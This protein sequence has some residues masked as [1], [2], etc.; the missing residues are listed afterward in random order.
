[1]NVKILIACIAWVAT[2][3]PSLA[4]EWPTGQAADLLRIAAIAPAE[5]LA[6][7]TEKITRL[8]NVLLADPK[9]NSPALDTAA[10]DLF[11]DLASAF[12]QG[13]VAPL[14]VDKDWHLAPSAPD[15]VRLKADVRAGASPS[16]V[17]F[18]LLPHGLDYQALRAELAR[19][20][21]EPQSKARDAK[22]LQ[23]RANM[24]R[25]RWLPRQLPYDRI[26]VR[27]PA[28]RVD[29]YRGAVNV[30][31]HDA[32]VGARR[33]P[34]PS[35]VASIQ[36]LTLNPYW[37]PPSSI[38]GA[39][40]ISKYRRNPAAAVQDGFEGVLANGQV[41][42]ASQID[43]KAKPFPYNLRQRPGPRNAL[44][45]VRFNLPNPYAVYLHDTPAR[46]LFE[47]K[48]RALSHGCI[49]VKDPLSLAAALLRD[50]AWDEAS[51]TREAATSQTTLI[52]LP[53]AIPVYVLYLTTQV[54]EDGSIVYDE[55]I[56]HR[57]EKLVA[58]LD[59]EKPVKQGL[60]GGP[61]ACLG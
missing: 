57:D 41:V 16:A 10:D 26:E 40:L 47:R 6:P 18:A 14:A 27:I 28:Y 54:R 36:S 25:W 48:V 31:T 19:I 1:V 60:A 7:R 12:A 51:L 3:A 24:E 37:D 29:L 20:T 39:E 52:A 34:S 45:V 44:G 2:T 46:A 11:N 61:I 9:G 59:A 33:T 58:A 13:D 21:A 49:R 17:L 56:Y 23:T 5:G 53:A 35:F 4:A 8:E 30:A 43:W 22:L 42:D 32:I 55:D 38:E 50:P 15:L